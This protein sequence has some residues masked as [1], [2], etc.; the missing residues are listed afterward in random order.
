MAPFKR[1]I[2]YISHQ[3]PEER[4]VG[5]GCES[6]PPPEI[7]SNLEEIRSSFIVF[8]CLI[9]VSTIRIATLFGSYTNINGYVAEMCATGVAHKIRN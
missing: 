2:D 6:V 7:F 9:G 3:K 8:F 4:A 5:V 1:R